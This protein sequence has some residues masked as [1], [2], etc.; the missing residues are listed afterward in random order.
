MYYVNIC[1]DFYPYCWHVGSYY[2]FA[3]FFQL[4]LQRIQSYL[5]EKKTVEHLCLSVCYRHNFI[6]RYLL[7]RK[8]R[9]IYGQLIS[10]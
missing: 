2:I 1:Y 8:Y 7:A 5:P 9:R 6:N 3:L 10:T 4:S